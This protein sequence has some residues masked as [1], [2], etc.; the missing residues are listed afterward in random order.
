MAPKDVV[1]RIAELTPSLPEDRTL[2]HA[3]KRDAVAEVL[4]AV[5]IWSYTR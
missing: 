4:R 2:A 1:I 3:A 5:N